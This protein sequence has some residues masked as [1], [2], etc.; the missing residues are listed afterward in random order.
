MGNPYKNNTYRYSVSECLH[1]CAYDQRCLGIEIVVENPNYDYVYNA[2][3]LSLD[4]NT[5]GADALCWAK[6]EYC[7]PYFEAKDLNE[8][9]LKCYCPNNRKGFYTK[10]VQRT[11]NN[12]RFCGNDSLVEE[13]L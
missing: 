11:L 4:R 5:T 7:N 6:G 12:T 1:E 3:D 13:Q 9:M 2:A 8:A 10:R